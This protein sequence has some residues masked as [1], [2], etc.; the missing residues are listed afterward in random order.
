[1]A[2]CQGCQDLSAASAAEITNFAW[3]VSGVE[4]LSVLVLMKC[5]SKTTLRKPLY[6]VS[7]AQP[8]VGQCGSRFRSSVFAFRGLLF[9]SSKVKSR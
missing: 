5:T 6:I 7:F 3:A 8:V 9:V 1:M 4:G 2:T